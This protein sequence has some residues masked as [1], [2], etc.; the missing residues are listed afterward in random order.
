VDRIDGDAF[1]DSGSSG[2]EEYD[3][4]H[5]TATSEAGRRVQGVQRYDEL[6]EEG[7]L[8]KKK[9]SMALQQWY[10]MV[11]TAIRAH[12]RYGVDLVMMFIP[13]S[14]RF[15]CFSTQ[16]DGFV[17]TLSRVADVLSSAQTGKKRLVK[18][19]AAALLSSARAVC[20]VLR[21]VWRCCCLVV[22]ELGGPGR[23]RTARRGRQRRQ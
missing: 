5:V 16:R 11:T 22:C 23:A 2:D 12:H 20:E 18:M 1:E 19:D 8:L 3:P 17:A 7:P 6:P 4:R 14:L 15:Q 9:Q 21:R 13:K 10:R